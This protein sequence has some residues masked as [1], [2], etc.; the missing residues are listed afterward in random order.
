MNTMTV[1]SRSERLA[2]LGILRE[3]DLDPNTVLWRTPDQLGYV[4]GGDVYE[5]VR[6]KPLGEVDPM[7][8]ADA[9]QSAVGQPYVWDGS[10]KALGEKFNNPSAIEDMKKA[11]VARALGNSGIRPK[12]WQQWWGDNAGTHTW[13]FDDGRA[14]QGYMFFYV[15]PICSA[16]VLG[17]GGTWQGL[18]TKLKVEVIEEGNRTRSNLDWAGAGKRPD[19]KLEPPLKVPVGGKPVPYPKDSKVMAFLQYKKADGI[20]DAALVM[21]DL[22]ITGN[23]P[24]T[25]AGSPWRFDERLQFTR[26]VKVSLD[27]DT[28]LNS[29]S[30]RVDIGIGKDGTPRNGTPVLQI[31]GDPA[32]R[33]A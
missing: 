17:K 22:P 18:N 32:T 4:D 25:I 1:Y 21:V 2:R 26:T 30:I 5:Y 33:P 16:K 28:L 23:Y 10:V 29:T 12:D 13:K 3:P 31:V 20:Y 6:C 19:Q 24:E 14:I 15:L 27:K 8:L 9:I 7:G 11:A